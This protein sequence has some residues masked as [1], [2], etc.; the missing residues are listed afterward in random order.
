LDC[1]RQRHFIGDGLLRPNEQRDWKHTGEQTMSP[2]LFA[3]LL[4][5]LPVWWDQAP[6]DQSAGTALKAIQEDQRKIAE[7]YNEAFAKTKT[8][9]DGEKL[10][11][12]KRKEIQECVRRALQLAKEH[13]H[14]P[15]AFDA[16]VWIVTGGLGYFPE[17]W[18]ALDQIREHELA[19]PKLGDVCSAAGIYRLSYAGTE[20]FLRSAIKRNPDH[21]VQGRAVY[22]LAVVLRDYSRVSESLHSPE[23]AKRLDW[24][25]QQLADKLR[26]SAP[27]KLRRESEELYQRAADKYGDVKFPHSVRPLR[28]WAESALFELRNLQVGKVAPEIEG[29]DIDGKKFKLSDYRGKVVV[30]DFW[31]HW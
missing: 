17:T 2:A 5:F 6:G 19:N 4:A 29:E 27:E 30:L 8:D 7:K 21:S 23:K 18:E 12:A 24:L 25:P 22:T 31:G 16:R 15:A 1:G 3:T 20:D 11:E 14:D 10:Y 26:A 28:A 9:Q 13:S